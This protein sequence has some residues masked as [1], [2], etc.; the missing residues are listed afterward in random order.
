MNLENKNEQVYD[1]DITKTSASTY[2]RIKVRRYS[3]NL[4]PELE[5]KDR[6]TFASYIRKMLRPDL[7]FSMAYE[8]PENIFRLPGE[9]PEESAERMLR[10][11]FVS[12]G[13]PYA[14]GKEVDWLFNPTS[15]QYKEWTWQFSRHNEWKFLANRYLNTKDERYAACVAELFESWVRQAEYP[16][17]ALGYQTKCWRTI[18]C[19]I[20]MGANWPYTLHAFLES[21]SFTDDI[22][23]EWHESVW[24]HGK[25]LREHHMHGNWMIMEMNGLA[26]IAILCPFFEESEEWLSYAL[27]NLER[28]LSL[29]VYPDGFQYELA[30]GYHHV[31]INNYHRLIKVMRT[32]GYEVPESFYNVLERMTRVFIKL[33]MPD[34]R[35]PDIND[36]KWEPASYYIEPCMDMFGGIPDFEWAISEGRNGSQP[37][38][39]SAAFPYAGFSIMRTG[40]GKDDIWAL[41]DAAPFGR[42]HQHEDKL[43]ILLCAYGKMLLT[44]GG[45][46]AYDDSEMRQYV[47]STRAHN[48]LMINGEGQNR[49]CSYQWKEE[50]I[51]MHSGMKY[52][53]GEKEDFSEGIYEEGYG[54]DAANKASHT[55]SVYFMKDAPELM[56]FFLVAD[57]VYAEDR[58]HYEV[59]WHLNEEEVLLSMGKADTEGLHIQMSGDNSLEVLYGAEFP[60][61][62]GFVA[63]SAVQGDYRPVPTLRYGWFGSASRRVTLL[64]PKKEAAC[65][66][67]KLIA[68]EDPEDTII[69]LILS[70]GNEI[71]IDEKD[72][73]ERM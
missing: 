71:M 22:L 17:D 45:N 30:T 32:Y 64:Y 57:R 39:T 10:H 69:R 21:P 7:F 29:Q 50:E 18:E 6:K 38:Y 72:F 49:R 70:D 12:C 61:W 52:C 15:N 2:K 5:L 8:E 9:S 11:E 37:D 68:S 60:A 13:V 19:G 31:V 44:E 67:V 66:V 65:P 54:E 48:T 20:R 73:T 56:P 4:K 3:M 51:Q 25:R 28:E 62:H 1:G 36:G 33:R 55:R 34:G 23:Y 40:W 59:L 42:A 24:K 53:Y 27:K 41:F 43:S 35:T 47:L 14:F 63:N 46:Y 16:E 58:N 26:Q